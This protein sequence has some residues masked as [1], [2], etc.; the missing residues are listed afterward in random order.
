[1]RDT[2]RYFPF[3]ALV[4][5]VAILAAGLGPSCTGQ[6]PVKENQKPSRAILDEISKA[7]EDSAAIVGPSVVPI[8]AEQ[9][10]QVQSPFGSPDDPFRQ[11]FGDDFFKRFFGG[12]PE[13]PERRAVHSLGSGVIVSKDGYILTNNHVVEG[14]EKLTVILGDKKK[15]EGKIV[16]TD[17]QTDVAVIR[18]KAE[19]LP[20]ASLGDSDAVKIGQWV[21]AVGN[22]FQLMHTVT[23]GIISAK[24]RSDVGL[25]DYEDFIQ[26][27]ASIN[28]GNSGGALADLGGNVI[29]INT[30]IANPSGGGNVGIGFAIPINMARKVMD[31]LIAKGKVIRGFLSLN[32]QDI[33]EDLA[34]ALKLKTTQGALVV[35]VT[36][37]GP[38]EKAG[39]KRGDVITSFN[40]EK[41]AD[42]TELRN[43]VAQTAPGTTVK[44]G[45][46]RDG[47]ELSLNAVLAERPQGPAAKAPSAEA[48]EQLTSRKLGLGIQTLT[49]DIAQ[50]LGYTKDQGVVVTDV[51]PGS[52]ADDAGLQAGDLIKEVNKVSTKTVRDFEKAIG[53]LKKGD[54]AALLVRRG[55]TTSYV[56]IRIP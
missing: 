35:Q 3:L 2:K 11:F 43:K 50:Q 26:T 6:A 33:D 18:I 56:A 30:A 39:I 47:K 53:R 31:T 34:K 37:G 40:G 22:P 36:P 8:F 52:P 19:N 44:I 17:A 45:L 5:A 32:T 28:P 25:A 29:G 10:V 7:F 51:A 23:A 20:A 49:P 14:A 9:I 27:D 55:D 21:I 48:P 13:Q 16:G 1:M 42:G 12:A 15:Y 4:A 41:I 38:A 54:T 46:L 24:G